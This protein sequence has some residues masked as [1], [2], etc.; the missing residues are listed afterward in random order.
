MEKARQIRRIRLA[1][2]IMSIILTGAGVLGIIIAK[3]PSGIITSYVALSIGVI[4]FAILVNTKK[5]GNKPKL[6]TKGGKDE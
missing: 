3:T 6:W 2:L 1:L 4:L 5:S